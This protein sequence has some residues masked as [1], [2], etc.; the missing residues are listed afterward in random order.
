MKK[1]SLLASLICLA[2][3]SSSCGKK[4]TAPITSEGQSQAAPIVA[5]KPVVNVFL[6]RNISF[7]PPYR[8]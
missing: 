1:Y 2:I 7:G 5:E 3:I 4:G 6:E 8:C